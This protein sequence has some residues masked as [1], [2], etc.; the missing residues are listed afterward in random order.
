MNNRENY[1]NTASL[2]SPW[3]TNTTVPKRTRTRRLAAATESVTGDDD[4]ES[5]ANDLI[6]D[7]N[8]QKF[9]STGKNIIDKQDAY[10]TKCFPK[11]N[12]YL[13]TN[14]GDSFRDQIDNPTNILFCFTFNNSDEK[15]MISSESDITTNILVSKLD[16]N[17]SLKDNGFESTVDM[18]NFKIYQS[19]KSRILEKIKK[20]KRWSVKSS[21]E[22]NFIFTM[23]NKEM[24]RIFS[25]GQPTFQSMF[26]FIDCKRYSDGGPT[27]KYNTFKDYKIHFRKYFII[28]SI[29]CWDV[30]RSIFPT[31]IASYPYNKILKC[32]LPVYN[33]L[34]FD[35]AFYK[36]T[37][38][39]NETT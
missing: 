37:L 33:L 26:R 4:Y 9:L 38:S 8:S 30:Y 39:K 3:S 7:L 1:S 11:L 22:A 18:I 14:E 5:G 23:F 25:V 15:Y 16:S 28:N 36:N 34:P 35:P 21:H 13:E 29:N 12:H 20:Y 19:Y 32:N 17:Y 31:N 10:N 27:R 6:K 24:A 2:S